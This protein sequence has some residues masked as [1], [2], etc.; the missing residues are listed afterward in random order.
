MPQ[1]RYCLAPIAAGQWARDTHSEQQAGHEMYIQ[2]IAT[3][4]AL[5]FTFAHGI[6]ESV[7][8]LDK[9]EVTLQPR[10]TVLVA[11]NTERITEGEAA[12][13]VHTY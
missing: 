3:E 2:G 4:P 1:L 6:A 11:C 7:R 10:P 5:P 12:Q 8:N 9:V 13:H